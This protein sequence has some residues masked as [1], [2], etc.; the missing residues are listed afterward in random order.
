MHIIMAGPAF[1][2]TKIALE[3]EFGSDNNGTVCL[4][5][6]YEL[7]KY[8][9]LA[10]YR[11]HY[12]KVIVFNQ[13]QIRTKMFK[14]M[15]FEYYTMLNEADELWDYDEYNIEALRLIR[16]DIKLHIL[17]P[18]IQLSC[19]L[20]SNKTFDVLFYGAMNNHRNAVI[21]QLRKYN[22]NVVVPNKFGDNLNYYIARTKLCLNVH[23]YTD[24]ALQ[25]QA[26]M[27]RWVSAGVP[28]LS[29]VSRTNY[30]HINECNYNNIVEN[31]L[32][33]LK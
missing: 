5:G 1:I 31:V 16:S 11:M 8:H 2:D 6:A 7:A 19:K 17:K 15:N 24:T 30:M 12:K 26:R 3:A 13:E 27:I 28:I 14:F 9:T 4:L 25:E 29:E 33:R 32:C 18:C 22:I 23:Y 21:N 20:C 10:E